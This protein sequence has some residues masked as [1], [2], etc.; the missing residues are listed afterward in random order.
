MRERGQGCPICYLRTRPSSRAADCGK[1]RWCGSWKTS[2]IDAAARHLVILM[3]SLP[4]ALQLA[5]FNFQAC[6]GCG[7]VTRQ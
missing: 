4:P 3:H 2:C 7:P 6:N 1:M 5:G